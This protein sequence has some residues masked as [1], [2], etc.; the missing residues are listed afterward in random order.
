MGKH[1]AEDRQDRCRRL[2]ELP[3]RLQRQTLEVF[4]RLDRRRHGHIG[5]G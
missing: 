3:V 5:C 2:I 1:A 4:E